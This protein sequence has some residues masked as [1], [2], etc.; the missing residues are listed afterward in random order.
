MALHGTFDR[1]YGNL[2][3]KK[4]TYKIQI[5]VFKKLI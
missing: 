1:L 4:N 2:V 5:T 3:I